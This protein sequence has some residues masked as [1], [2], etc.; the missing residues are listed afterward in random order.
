MTYLLDTNTYI[1]YLNG[2]APNVWQRLVALPQTEL[3]V[4]A[5]VKAELYYG[6]MK[7][8]DPARARAKQ[9]VFLKALAS[10]PFDDLAAEISGR[11]RAEL[12]HAGTLIGSNDLLIAAITLAHDLTWS[13]TTS[14]SLAVSPGCAL[15]LG[16]RR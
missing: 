9:Q 13:P 11:I 1:R 12:A 2:R 16:N 6:A 4:C 3:C 15:R 14:T 5:V 8:S 7:S 10:L